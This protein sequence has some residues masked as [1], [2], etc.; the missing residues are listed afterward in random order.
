MLSMPV[1]GGDTSLLLFALELRAWLHAMGV[2]EFKE[3]FSAAAFLFAWSELLERD[4]A[5]AFFFDLSEAVDF[6]RGLPVFGSNSAAIRLAQ[7]IPNSPVNL[8]SRSAM[9]EGELDK[10]P[11]GDARPLCLSRAFQKGLELLKLRFFPS[12]ASSAVGV[13]TTGL[14]ASTGVRNIE[15]TSSE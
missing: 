11:P 13:S 5:E 10:L 7:G 1:L 8:L 9:G 6:E 4:L 3:L 12:R 2:N 15:P 14:W